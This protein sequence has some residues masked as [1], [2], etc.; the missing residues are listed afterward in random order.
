[1]K[2]VALLALAAAFLVGCQGDR[3][4]TES[5]DNT[6]ATLAK[7]AAPQAQINALM[8]ALFNQPDKK[9]ANKLF[10][11]VKRGMA[12]G[13]DSYAQ[14]QAAQLVNLA[15]DAL[16]GGRLDD[17]DGMT[18]EEGVALLI[19]LLFEFVGLD[20]PDVDPGIFESVEWV[21][22]AVTPAGA[23]VLT[24]FFHAGVRIPAGALQE[25]ELISIYYV[26]QNPC[27]PTGLLQSEGCWQYEKSGEDPF[28]LDVEVAIC[29]D[30]GQLEEDYGSYLTDLVRLHKYDP[31][32]GVTKLEV[33]DGDIGVDCDDFALPEFLGDAGLLKNLG[34]RIWEFLGPRPLQAALAET[35]PKK[36]GGTTGSFTDM[37]G[38]V[39]ADVEIEDGD[40]QTA[41]AGTPVP[42]DP[43]VYVTD[44]TGAAL[45]G[46]EIYWYPQDGSV[47]A[48][49][50]FTDSEGLASMSWTLGA[51]GTNEL[52][53]STDAEGDSVTFTANAVTIPAGLVSWWPADG[54]YS[55][56]VSGN[57]GAPGYDPLTFVTGISGQAFQ[58]DGTYD[59]VGFGGENLGELQ[60]LTVS[61]WVNLDTEGPS[62][63]IQRFV[64]LFNE[65][66]VLRQDGSEGE[67]RILHFYMNF[68]PTSD[69]FWQLRHI[70]YAG[71]DAGCF[72]HVAGTY[73]GSAMRLY[74]NGVLVGTN[75]VAGT[76]NI[77]GGGGHF[78]NEPEPLF[79]LLDE[80]QV[81]DHAL[82]AAAIEDLYDAGGTGT[83]APPTPPAAPGPTIDGINSPGEWT[84]AMTFDVFSGDEELS[85]ST[86]YVLSDGTNLN[87]ALDV[88]DGV[89][90][91]SDIWEIRFDNTND[92]VQVAY[93]DELRLSSGFGD[94][95]FNGTYWGIP[96][97]VKD[98]T[99]ASAAY[100]SGAGFFEISHPLGSGDFQ[101]FNVW[102]GAVLGICIRYFDDGVATTST[103]WPEG[104]VLTVNEQTLY[105]EIAIP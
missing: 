85:G 71:L 8:H 45:E 33:A 57:D 75:Y 84:G 22:Q 86:L 14:A 46:V 95:N 9:S 20:L 104:C 72:N 18:A 67:D 31:E 21:V 101:D 51:V 87:L 54:Y 29:V 1:M 6:Q 41:G 4:P 16:N 50:S 76:V 102:S 74:L 80:V 77:S 105:H 66:A 93:E 40:G 78:S 7:G 49:S 100:G 70:W 30:V 82:G 3:L 25:T 32:E 68:S 99:G 13:D 60:Q 23:T 98:G 11:Q 91:A 43:T 88:P 53:A 17:P 12:R 19:D 37:G 58:F 42:V 36:L 38:A 90:S 2:R 28:A 55:D 5:P 27:L 81:Y 48:S 103:T 10:A 34:S 15:T 83:C 62:G 52:I 97:A 63:D 35:R 39:E 47:G 26:N 73:D 59:L 96:D 65:K 89:Y 44:S 64:T 92:K 61:A 24:N 56:I 94:G 69:E 79:G